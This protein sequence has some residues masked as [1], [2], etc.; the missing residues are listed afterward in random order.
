M[1]G[2]VKWFSHK[3]AYGFIL[4]E[5]GNDYFVHLTDCRKEPVEGQDAT[6]EPSKG[7]KGLA[8]KNVEV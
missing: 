6:F 4:G 3:K 2:K 8:A 5:D 1:Q 7:A